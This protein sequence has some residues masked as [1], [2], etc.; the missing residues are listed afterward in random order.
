M[1]RGLDLDSC[2]VRPGVLEAQFDPDVGFVHRPF[3]D[4]V[5]PGVINAADYNLGFQGSAYSDS[6]HQC[7]NGRAGRG[8]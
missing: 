5:I 8:K 7:R 1:A 6:D 4:H 3:K 2:E